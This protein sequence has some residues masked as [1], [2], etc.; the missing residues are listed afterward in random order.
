MESRRMLKGLKPVEEYIPR[1]NQRRCPR[2]NGKLTEELNGEFCS[3][4]KCGYTD[5]DRR[6]Y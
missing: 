1:N 3:S 4:S 5:M 2:C 6:E